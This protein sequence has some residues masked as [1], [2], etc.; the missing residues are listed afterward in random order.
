MS[1][2]CLPWDAC[3]S[4][5]VLCL[6]DHPHG[7][8]TLGAACPS[9]I[10]SG[11]WYV[12]SFLASGKTPASLAL[13]KLRHG[14]SEKLPET[15]RVKEKAVGSSVPPSIEL[16]LAVRTFVDRLW[17]SVSLST[18]ATRVSLAFQALSWVLQSVLVLLRVLRQCFYGHLSLIARASLSSLY[19]HVSSYSCYSLELLSC[20]SWLQDVTV[21]A[22]IQWLVILLL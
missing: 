20:G 5:C 22:Y 6:H 12:Q 4:V 13:R 7:S 3:Y 18:L 11:A 21:A 9:S 8:L 19:I 17:L 15:R 1:L 10:R 2:S 16:V 14:G